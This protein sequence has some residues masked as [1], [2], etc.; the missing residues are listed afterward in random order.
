MQVRWPCSLDFVHETSITTPPSRVRFYRD[1]RVGHRSVTQSPCPFDEQLA[2]VL[3]NSYSSYLHRSFFASVTCRRLRHFTAKRSTDWP[4]ECCESYSLTCFL[5]AASSSTQNPTE[6]TR[7]L[8]KP[9]RERVA[10][11]HVPTRLYSSERYPAKFPR[12]RATLHS[13]CRICN[14][15]FFYMRQ[16]D[17][18][19]VVAERR[20]SSPSGCMEIVQGGCLAVA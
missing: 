7:V 19:C 14:A 2:C 8:E 11:R 4:W 3:S 10:N 18:W 17:D 16:Y 1:S 6:S 12:T 13:T 5:L 20:L 15:E 9:A